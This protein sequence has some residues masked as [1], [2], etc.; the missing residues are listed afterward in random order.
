[1]A[2]A[3]LLIIMRRK[4]AKSR[5]EKR[6][7]L[8]TFAAERLMQKISKFFSITS[9]ADNKDYISRLYAETMYIL[10]R[11]GFVRPPS[12][13]PRSFADDN[14]RLSS[15]KSLKNITAMLEEEQ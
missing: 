13:T 8:I 9:N 4:L 6:Y 14:E 3:E 7:N 2:A 11:K 1:M 12:Q 10:S 5:R 15:F